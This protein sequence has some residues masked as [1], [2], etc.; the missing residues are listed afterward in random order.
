MAKDHGLCNGYS[1]VDV[2]KCQELLLLVAAEHIVLLDS[3]QRFLLPF[4]FDDIGVRHDP[5]C[6][7]PHRVLKAFTTPG[8]KICLP[9]DAYALVLVALCGN[10]DISLVQDKHLDLLGVDELELYAPVQ[11]CARSADD[12]L[13][14][15]LHPSLHFIYQSWTQM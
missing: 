14:L 2:A 8:S 10:H 12:N 15:D 1:P 13:F 4:Q 5:L 9:L 11:H 7:L 3:V 6:E